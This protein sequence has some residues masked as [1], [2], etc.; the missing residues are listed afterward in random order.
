M[1]RNQLLRISRGM[2]VLPIHS[3]FGTRA[4]SPTEVTQALSRQF[5]EIITSH[6]A[7]AANKLGLTTQVPS[8][9]VYLTSGSNRRLTLGAQ[10]VDLIHAQPWQLLFPNAY[11]G[12]A[13]R[14]LDWLGSEDANM[15]IEKI[16]TS[17]LLQI[18]SRRQC[19]PIW[20]HQAI[21]ASINLN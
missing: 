10:T 17:A 19:L 7:A 12:D 13:I 4:P 8:K 11:A 16:P 21:D 14:A 9:S 1:H 2:Y 18:A 5:S 6:G 15:L 3:R 20:M